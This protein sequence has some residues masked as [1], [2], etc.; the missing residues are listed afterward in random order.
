MQCNSPDVTDVGFLPGVDAPP[1]DDE[2]VGPR[3]SL[4]ARVAD[5]GLLESVL[6][7]TVVHQLLPRHEA[8]AA[9][10][11]LKVVWKFNVCICRANICSICFEISNH[12]KSNGYCTDVIVWQLKR[13]LSS[14]LATKS[15]KKIALYLH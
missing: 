9:V 12:I 5:V 3:E 1:V 15:M 6:G 8:L 13:R 14:L 7:A 11:A 4:A 2:P 10:L